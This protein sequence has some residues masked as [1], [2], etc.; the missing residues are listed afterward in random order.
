VIAES[1]DRISDQG[2]LLQVWWRDDDAVAHT[3]ALDRLLALAGQAGMPLAI[4]A[5]PALVEPS[6]VQ[7]LSG[8]ERVAVLVHGLAHTN[9]APDGAKKAEFGPHRPLAALERE[10][11]Q[12]LRGSRDAFGRQ[13]LN[14]FVPPWNRI[15]PELAAA[16]PRLGFGGMS[17]FG[18]RSAALPHGLAVVNTHL[19][20]VD[21]R[22]SGGLVEAEAFGRMW[23]R[24]LEGDEPVGLLTHHLTAAEAVWSFCDALVE[25][26]AGHPAVTF[27]ALAKLLLAASTHGP[28]GDPRG[29]ARWANA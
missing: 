22:G 9:H 5:V 12:G 21:W 19:D 2:R 11:A 6:L 25:I 13:A 1:L 4:A 26:M 27:P 28:D 29:G 7:R 8:E 16:L 14:V 10:A 24:A 17:T 15:A 18:A 3:P 20:P 23:R